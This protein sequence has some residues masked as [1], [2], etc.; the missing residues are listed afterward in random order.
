MLH[1]GATVTVA[2]GSAAVNVYAPEAGQPH[3]LFTVAATALPKGT[4]PPAPVI[5]S[6]S[7]GI[8]VRAPLPLANLL[9]RVPDRVDLVI[10][11]R[12]GDVNV[13]DITG[14]ARVMARRGNVSLML[15]GYGQ[16]TV[17]RG[18]LSVIMGGT[19][20]PGTL[21]FATGG[22]DIE[23]R[24]NPNAPCSVHLHTDAGTLFTDFGLRGSSSGTAETID[25]VIGAGSSQRIDV[26]TRAGSIRLLR[27][28][29]Q[30]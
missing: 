18:N 13:T 22:G 6:R 1:P 16:A 24:L 19:R 14:S 3:D 29:P 23:I 12:D 5:F 2:A 20:W 28:Q 11:S 4:P 17:G 27:L 7:N 9:V 8:V 26:E 15:P 21:F 10:D 25:G 30:A